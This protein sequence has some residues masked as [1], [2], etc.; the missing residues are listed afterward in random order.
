[1]KAYIILHLNMKKQEYLTPTTD[2]IQFRLEMNVMSP[3]A[4]GQDL[5]DPNNMDFWTP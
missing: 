2:I 1:M 4:Q 5:G 3:K